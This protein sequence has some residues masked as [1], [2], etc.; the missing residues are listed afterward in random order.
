MATPCCKD[1]RYLWAMIGHMLTFTRIGRSKVYSAR[2]SNCNHVYQF[3][4][5]E[6]QKAIKGA[7]DTADQNKGSGNG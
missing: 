7:G 3:G 1:G 2:C 5:R 6:M 4:P